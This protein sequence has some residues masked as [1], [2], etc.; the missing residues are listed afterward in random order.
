MVEAVPKV[1]RMP[2]AAIDAAARC[3]QE[4][5][6]KAPEKSGDVRRYGAK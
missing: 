5:E 1:V 6:S 3:V 4:R 2:D